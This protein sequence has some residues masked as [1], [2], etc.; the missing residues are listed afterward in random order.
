MLAFM[1]SSDVCVKNQIWRLPDASDPKSLDSAC[2]GALS[3]I[4]IG[5]MGFALAIINVVL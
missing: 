2:H 4:S 1:I 5:A 3:T